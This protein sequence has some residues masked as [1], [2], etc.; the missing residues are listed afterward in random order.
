MNDQPEKR[1]QDDKQDDKQEEPQG[2]P[3][4]VDEEMDFAQALNESARLL[5]ANRPGEAVAILERLHKRFPHDP[6]VAVNLG[7][8]LI[9]QRKWNR[10][11]RVLEE[12]TRHNPESTMLWMNL[13][14]ARLG[15][16]E[17]SGPRQQRAAIAAFEQALRID[18]QTPNAHYHLALIY[19]EQG[20]LSRASALFQRALEVNPADR[21]AKYWLDRLSRMILAQQRK[22][23]AQADAQQKEDNPEAGFQ[24]GEEDAA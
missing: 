7:G 2:Q 5:R 16:L 20:N 9:L 11:V 24:A 14:A 8:A 21:D 17:T 1:P 10:A 13:G 23:K 22:K 12:A 6:D 18:P 3:A 19:K 15:R 4:A